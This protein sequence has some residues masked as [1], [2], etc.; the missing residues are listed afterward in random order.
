MTAVPAPF[1]APGGRLAVPVTLTRYVRSGAPVPE[2]ADFLWELVVVLALPPHPATTVARR[3]RH[4]A[5]SRGAAVMT[6]RSSEAGV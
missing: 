3:T 4:G 5:S 6:F 1:G 2:L